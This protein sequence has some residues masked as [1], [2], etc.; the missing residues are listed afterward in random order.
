MDPSKRYVTKEELARIGVPENFSAP[1]HKIFV[2]KMV[3][4]NGANMKSAW[5]DG[6]RWVPCVD[7]TLELCTLPVTWV[8]KHKGTE[9]ISKDSVPEAYA[10]GRGIVGYLHVSVNALDDFHGAQRKCGLPQTQIDLDVRTR[11][12]TAHSM[13]DQLVH[14]KDAILEMDKNPTYR[15]PGETWGKNKISM[16][17]WDYLEEGT[18]ILSD[19][20]WASQFLEGDKYPTSS[21]VVPMTF[22]MMATSS[23]RQDVKFLN[24][25]EDEDNDATI[26]PVTVPHA[27]LSAKIQTVRA[28]MHEQLIAR[29]DADVPLD[30][31]KFWF[32][33]SMCD[34]RFKKLTFKN[35]RMLTAAMRTNAEKW[36]STEFNR[37]Y[38]NKFNKVG[39]RLVGQRAATGMTVRRP[40][41]T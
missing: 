17:M 23:A 35:D 7:H 30:V 33:S 25:E 4:D 29:F 37:N 10:H 21:L 20:A 5:N 13:G 38:K 3:S 41:G 16:T 27:D 31:K 32:I 9:T 1:S 40:R 24:R 19:A 34:P 14:N 2:F 6:E 15:D 18:A 11:W 22:R 36:F 12:R 26:N 39:T 8:Q 28:A